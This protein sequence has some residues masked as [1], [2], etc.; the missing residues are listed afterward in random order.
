MW[1]LDM[2]NDSYYVNFAHKHF[3]YNDHVINITYRITII[4][5]LKSHESS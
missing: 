3:T 1:A 5:P 2:S 4:A